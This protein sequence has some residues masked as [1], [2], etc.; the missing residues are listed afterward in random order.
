MTG[1][2]PPIYNISQPYY[3]TLQTFAGTWITIFYEQTFKDIF[4]HLLRKKVYKILIKSQRFHPI[5]SCLGVKVH[6]NTFL[7]EKTF[8][9][10][11]FFLLLSVKTKRALSTNLKSSY[12]LEKY[13]P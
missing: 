1:F 9:H 7:K 8:Y 2:H 5:L 11:F 3:N 12:T 4:V 10:D 13:K 6:G